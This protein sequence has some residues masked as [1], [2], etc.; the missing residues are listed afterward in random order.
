[1][2]NHPYEPSLYYG[3]EKEPE[4]HYLDFNSSVF[5][6]LEKEHDVQITIEY[7]VYDNSH[8]IVKCVVE[9]KADFNYL[10]ECIVECIEF[11]LG[12]VAHMECSIDY[13]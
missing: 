13:K 7:Y 11:R 10:N 2:T 3:A 12:K 6:E 9:T 4:F 1:M 8:R 5:D